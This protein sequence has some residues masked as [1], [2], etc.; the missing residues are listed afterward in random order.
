MTKYI[1]KA[2]L[3]IVFMCHSFLANAQA[4]LPELKPTAII[5]DSVVT[6]GDLFTDLKEK[7]DIVV[8]NAPEPGQKIL[9]SARHV[10]KVTRQNNVRWRNSVGVKNITVSRM[11]TIVSIPELKD[12]LTA[13]LKNLSYTEKNLDLRFYNKNGKIHLPNGYDVADLTVRNISLDKKSDKF[14]ALIGAPTGGG[15]ETLHT[16]NGRILRV[17]MVPTL[18]KTIRSGEVIKSTDITWTSLPD[19]QVSRNM[20]RSQDKLIG[21]TPRSQIKEGNPIRLNEIDRP[22]LIKRGSLV[23]VHFSS[24]KINLSTLGKAMEKGGL[25]DVIQVKNNTSNKLISAIVLG[26]NQVQVNTDASKLVLLNP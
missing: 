19:Q 23:K 3:L 24:A 9:I 20:I 1:Y 6:L 14:S 18:S 7:Q 16:V 17:T 26:P 2:S 5:D 4:I 21:M 15:G 12:K 25:G 13:E 11:S 8:A 10:L 22:V